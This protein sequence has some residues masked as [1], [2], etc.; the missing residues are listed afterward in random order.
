VLT[1]NND[2]RRIYDRA[3]RHA[4]DGV[5]D[6][7]FFF[8]FYYT[9]QASPRQSRACRRQNKRRAYTAA[10]G[11][12]KKREEGCGVDIWSR[13]FRRTWE[14]HSLTIG[15]MYGWGLVFL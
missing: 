7:F 14:S 11:L 1:R 9:R 3:Q 8:F 13:I 12:R 4:S 5:P 2:N 10:L 15:V 6:S